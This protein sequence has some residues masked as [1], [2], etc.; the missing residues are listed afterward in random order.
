MK[1]RTI[2]FRFVAS[3]RMNLPGGA[4]ERGEESFLNSLLASFLHSS[5]QIHEAA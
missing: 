4:E 2:E 5:R 3:V 1:I